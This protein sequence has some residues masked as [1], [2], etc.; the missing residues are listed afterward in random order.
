MDGFGRIKDGL[1]MRGRMNALRV[2]KGIVVIGLF[3]LGV[4][5]IPTVRSQSSANARTISTGRLEEHV[6]FDSSYHRSRR[7]WVYTPAGYDAHRAEPYPLILAFDGDEYRDLMPLPHILD[8]LSS[9][10]YAP[11]FVAVLI[12]D[13]IGGVRLADLCNCARMTGFLGKQL[14]PWLR[15]G[16]RVTSD[17]R[18]VIATGSSAGGLGAAF[19]AFTSPELFGNVWSQSGAFWRGAEASNEEPWE[20]LTGKVKTEPKKDIRFFLD[21]GELEDH[22]T[23]SGS[24]PNFRDANR[25]FKDALKNK[26]YDVTYLEVPGGNHA[27]RWW[28]QR[29]AVGIVTLSKGWAQEPIEV[30]GN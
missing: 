11:K 8:S 7:T 27:E 25:R 2:K 17:P 10:G 29:L 9:N 3:G 6:L 26:G 5:F 18:Q 1:N 14:V 24:G 13:S 30:R 28:S 23:L 4:V 20:W 22:R 16:W 19:V 21:V 12:D 15:R